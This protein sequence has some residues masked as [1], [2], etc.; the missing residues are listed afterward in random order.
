MLDNQLVSLSGFVEVFDSMRRQVEPV[1]EKAA[2]FIAESKFMIVRANGKMLP[3]RAVVDK[4]V[5]AQ[6]KDA[7][8]DKIGDM[9]DDLVDTYVTSPLTDAAT[10]YVNN[11]SPG[12]IPTSDS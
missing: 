2:K 3:A 1:Q 11:I 10:S 4:T 7:I 6:I 5:M 9:K 12:L 8:S